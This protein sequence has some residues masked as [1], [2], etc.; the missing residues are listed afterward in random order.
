MFE[1]L[2]RGF[3]G[4]RERLAGVRALT[5]EN[6]EEALRDVRT[7]LLEADVDFI[8]VKDFLARV[9]ERALGE[10]VETRVKDASGRTH[11][12]TPGQHFVAICEEELVALMGPVDPELAS[13]GGVTSIMLLGLQ[14]VGKTTI[15]AKLARHLQKKG[16]RPLLVAADTYRPAAA[17]QLEQLGAGIDVRVHRGRR[18]R[19]PARDLPSRARARPRRRLRRHHL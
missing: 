7:S 2:T 11:R 3:G 1:T 13:A 10:K 14:G 4:A 16:R 5:E 12:I 8:V 17:D 19:D 15:A 9:K 18:G 6:V